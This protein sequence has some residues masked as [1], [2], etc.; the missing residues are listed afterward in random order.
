MWQGVTQGDKG[1]RGGRKRAKPFTH[2]EAIV[3]LL[4]QITHAAL[5]ALG[6]SQGELGWQREG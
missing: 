6:E 4:A 5:L 1:P 2:L 3:P